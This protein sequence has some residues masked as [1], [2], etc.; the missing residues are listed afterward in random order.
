MDFR[1]IIIESDANA[2][3]EMTALIRNT[4]GYEVVGTF[5]NASRSIGQIELFRPNLF[6]VD[7][8][9]IMALQTLPIFADICPLATVL[10]MM[11][12][13]D[14][15]L[16]DTVMKSGAS[17]CILM[18]FKMADLGRAIELFARRGKRGSARVLTFWGPKGR[19]GSTT[20]VASLAMAIAKRS[21]E[22]VCVI[23]ADLQFGDLPV[24]FDAD[25]QNTILEVCRD[26]H[27]LS[28][29]SLDSYFEPIAEGVYLLSGP[30]R[31][32]Y[33]EF[34]DA[35]GLISVIR[36]ARNLF[37]YV[38]VDLPPGFNPITVAIC[39]YSDTDFVSGMLNSGFEP[40]HMKRALDRFRL[41]NSYGKKIYTIFSRVTPCT[42]EH[43]KQLEEEIDFPIL[44]IMP[45]EYNLLS[46]AN[47]GFMSKGLPSDSVFSQKINL[48]ANEIVTGKR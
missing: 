47:S 4:P 9:D 43:K 45:N 15:N 30:E 38:L 11:P 1:V 34:I 31:P 22:A 37:R 8:T 7:V 32:E 17:G 33:A 48:L 29:V 23:D 19:S 28:P 42:E 35:E 46:V 25:P 39:E 21:G 2:L 13:W 6:L 27:V 44:E 3:E 20:L 16:A 5:Q 18:P 41:W 40:S 26:F 36:M 12:S 14:P 24:F 10:A